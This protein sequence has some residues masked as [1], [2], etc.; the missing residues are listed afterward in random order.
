MGHNAPESL[1]VA[2]PNAA[3]WAVY[4]SD[5]DIRL[6]DTERN[7]VPIIVPQHFAVIDCRG[8]R[9]L[10]LDLQFLP[11]FLGMVDFR[12]FGVCRFNLIKHGIDFCY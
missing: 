5:F 12:L 8:H 6:I 2:L 3:E 4:V 10:C 11:T 9:Y 7:Q 1:V